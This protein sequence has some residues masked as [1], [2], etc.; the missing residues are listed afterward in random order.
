MEQL[1]RRRVLK[2]LSAE[3][4]IRPERVQMLL[5]WKNSGFNL[6]ASVRVAAGNT[7]GREN[8][9][10]Y[11]IRAPF[12][13]EKIQYLPERQTVI[14]RG[15][16]T[17][18]LNRNY[19]IYDPLEFLAAATSHI[20]DRGEHLVRYYS[21][22]SSVKRGKRRKL[23]LEEPAEI[24]AIAEDGL[25]GKAARRSWARLIR[26][27]YEVDPLECP[28]CGS[29][30][31]IVAFI[32]DGFVVHKILKHLMLWEEPIPR[33]PPEPEQPPDIEYVPSHD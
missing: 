13:V 18:G 10:R 6:D 28:E 1:F 33:A 11:L 30:L 19:Q 27:V 8:I 22:Y 29:R 15:K 21:W 3:G 12:S 25:S 20:P 17:G 31:R 4:L 2:M 7:T 14:Y 23:G 16:M 32:E 24:T 5:G 9:S 26:K